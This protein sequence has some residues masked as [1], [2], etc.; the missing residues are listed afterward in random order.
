[1]SIFN[2]NE[3]ND[4]NDQL[5]GRFST[6]EGNGQPHVVPVVFRRNPARDA[7][8]I[9]GHALEKTAKF[10]YV[11]GHPRAAIVVDDLASTDPRRP[12]GI[13]IREIIETHRDGGERIVPGFVDAWMRLIPTRSVAW[14]LA[15]DPALPS[16]RSVNRSSD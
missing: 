6:V 10:R 3:I 12:R 16:K 1:M 15:H 13:E 5:L 7:I 14:G 2:R 9:G 11:Q 8:D 4:R